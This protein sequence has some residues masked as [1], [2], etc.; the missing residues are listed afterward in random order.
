MN[1]VSI[2]GTGFFFMVR[3]AWSQMLGSESSLQARQGELFA[4]RQGQDPAQKKIGDGN[5]Q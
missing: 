3:P 1:P 2:F 5:G 4:K